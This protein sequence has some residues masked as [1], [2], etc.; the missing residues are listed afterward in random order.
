MPGFQ[1]QLAQANIVWGR[2]E[3]AKIALAEGISAFE[4]LRALS[5]EEGRLSSLDQSW[6]L[7]DVAVQLA[8][9]EKDYP[10]AFAMAERARV[11]TVA[12]ARR[13]PVPP[14]VGRRAGIAE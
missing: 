8:I 3:A 1:L 9:E 13:T 2:T 4:A 10:K 14:L 7:F 5:T 6:Q 12:E 11:R